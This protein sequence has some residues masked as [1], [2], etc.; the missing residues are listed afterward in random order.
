[1]A[2]AMTH[3]DYLSDDGAHYRLKEDLSN[4]TAAGNATAT[5]SVHLPGGYHPRHIN[6]SHP[7]TGRERKISIGDPTNPIWV[8]GTIVITLTDFSTTPSA[9]V[10]YNVLSRVGEKRLN[11]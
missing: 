8:G 3:S 5:S 11:Q 4:A 2:G 7:V 9:Q 10:A 1:M 6:A